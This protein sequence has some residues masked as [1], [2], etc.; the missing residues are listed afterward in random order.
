MREL[1]VVGVE[2]GFIVVADDD[3]QRGRVPLEQVMQAGARSPVREPGSDRRLSPREIQGH[4]RSGLAAET[5]SSMTGVPLDYIRKFEGPVLA[6][7]EFIVDSALA[8][9]VHTAN[10][11]SPIDGENSFGAII[12][13]RLVGIGAGEG[14][15]SSWKEQQGDWIVAV[16]YQQGEVEHEARWRFDP[17]KHA[18][19]PIGAEAE[20]LSQQDPT[21][22]AHLPRLRA[23]TDDEHRPE[24]SRF[25]SGAFQP[26]AAAAPRSVDEPAA[27][28][29]RAAN[30]ALDA[31]ISRN[32]QPVA[33]PSH[34]ADLLEA[35]RR[36]RGEREAAGSAAQA[37]AAERA[38]QAHPATGSV[39]VQPTLSFDAPSGRRSASSPASATAAPNPPAPSE[40]ADAPGRG[41]K[42]RASM[43]SWDEIVFGARPDDDS[44]S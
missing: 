41:R 33:E 25:D 42:R 29:G 27:A 8:V 6:E 35:L 20:R 26:A 44:A 14:T 2:N 31:A 32:D 36:R 11:T 4:I 21:A 39:P 9:P 30:P 40:Q 37:E 3:G 1:R 34:T 15:W 19:A 23:V 28:S 12:G 10:E 24:P 22:P 5:V 18:L 17:R 7:R 38:R 43:P 13:K 16:R